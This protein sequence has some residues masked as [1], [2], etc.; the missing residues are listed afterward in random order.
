MRY[1]IILILFTGCSNLKYIFI[2]S[3]DS[4]EYYIISD[5]RTEADYLRGNC[6]KKIDTTRI[7]YLTNLLYNYEEQLPYNEDNIKLV[8][9]LKTNVLSLLSFNENMSKI[10]CLEK[11]DIII[12]NSKAIQ[13]AIGVNR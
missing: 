9:N 7:V 3:F 11:M 2:P 12:D 5:I 13:Q 6:N 4:N 8:F 1:L 10:Y